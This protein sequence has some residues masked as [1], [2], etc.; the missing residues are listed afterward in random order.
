MAVEDHRN[1]FPLLHR[2]E[3][4]EFIGRKFDALEGGRDFLGD[5]GREGLGEADQLADVAG[6]AVGA[7]QPDRIRAEGDLAHPARLREIGGE[8]AEQQVDIVLAVAQ[9]RNPDLRRAQAEIKVLAELAAPDGFVQVDVGGRDDADIGV[10]HLVGAH[11]AELAGLEHPQQQG[12]GFQREFGDLIQEEG[13]AVGILEIAL[14]GFRG[15]GE[16]ALDMAEEFGIHE[17]FREGAAVHHE[18]TVHAP[19][20]VL[21]DDSCEVFLSD[22]AFAQDEDTQVRGRELHRRLQR[23]VQRRIVADDVIFVFQ[24]L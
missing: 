6:P 7:Q 20:R 4:G 13:A 16:R 15:P 19:G 18:E 9:G 8:L 17:F 1:G 14:A 21:V 10:L 23:L 11:L 5:L 3:R 2:H 24:C 22:T 12:L